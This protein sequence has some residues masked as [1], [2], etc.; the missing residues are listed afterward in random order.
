MCPIHGLDLR[1]DVKA[2]GPP[3]GNT[4]SP[5]AT[6]VATAGD[7]GATTGTSPLVLT[8]DPQAERG[9]TARRAL[10]GG[11]LRLEF[12]PA[13]DVAEIARLAAAEHGCCRL[14]GFALVIDGRGLALEAHAPPDGQ[15]VLADLFGTA[16]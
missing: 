16:D 3:M 13:S 14:F 11:G 2:Y 6:P 15:P 9:V 5:W 10:E 4:T 1:V 12:A 7:P 8:H